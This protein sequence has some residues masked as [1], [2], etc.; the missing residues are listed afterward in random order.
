MS[1]FLPTLPFG[2][3]PGYASYRGHQGAYKIFSLTSHGPSDLLPRPSNYSM[4]CT[5]PWLGQFIRY[6]ETCEEEDLYFP[7]GIS[8]L[9][10]KQHHLY[11]NKVSH[12]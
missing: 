7:S 6:G 11:T 8:I 1:L 12:D 5:L 9:L 10:D 2:S 3:P 4:Q